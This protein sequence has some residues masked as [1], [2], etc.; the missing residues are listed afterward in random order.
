MA[1][2]TVAIPDTKI[3]NTHPRRAPFQHKT[4][5]LQAIR[6]A[7]EEARNSHS[8]LGAE[9]E[10]GRAGHARRCYQHQGRR[11]TIRFCSDKTNVSINILCSHS[12]T[13]PRWALAFITTTCIWSGVFNRLQSTSTNRHNDT[14]SFAPPSAVRNV[15]EALCETVIVVIPRIYGSDAENQ[16]RSMSTN[17][18]CTEY[19]TVHWYQST[20]AKADKK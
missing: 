12:V 6:N 4:S 1:F 8:R 17:G 19:L 14:P 11:K 9:I 20:Q 5:T 7:K 18:E 10:C 2:F 15:S 3:R 13:H 16:K